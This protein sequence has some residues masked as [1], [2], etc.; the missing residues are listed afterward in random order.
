MLRWKITLPTMVLAAG[1]ALCVSSSYGTQEYAKKEKKACTYCHAKMA[2]DKGEM[3]KN[4]NDT[5]TCYETNEHS[6]AKCSPPK[7]GS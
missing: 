4:L 5:G 6:L 2:S 7:K 3:K 1:M